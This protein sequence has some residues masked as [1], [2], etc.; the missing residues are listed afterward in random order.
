MS[1]YVIAIIVIVALGV[2]ATVIHIVRW[3]NLL[4]NSASSLIN[5]I[6]LAQVKEAT[7][8]KSLSAVEKFVM[9]QL[10]NDFPE[11][12]VAAAIDRVKTDAALFYRSAIENKVLFSDNTTTALLENLILPKDVKGNIIIHKAALSAYNKLGHDRILTYQA[13]AEYMDTSDTRNQKRLILK[14]IAASD[15]DFSQNIHT[16]TCPNCGAPVP[17]IG[18]KVCKYCGIALQ[19]STSLGWYLMDIREG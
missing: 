12:N 13:S 17:T 14:Y 19:T 4:G 8:P 18:D 7:V 15:D 1:W 2:L 5:Q 11:F 16:F 10:L 6:K 3:I 9:P